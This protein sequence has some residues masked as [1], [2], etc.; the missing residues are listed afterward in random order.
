M[1]REEEGG[2]FMQIAW[3]FLCIRSGLIISNEKRATCSF[4]LI[5]IKWV[6][7]LHCTAQ[8]TFE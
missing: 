8:I 3:A 5:P 7:I 6:E 4:Q 2:C 1:E